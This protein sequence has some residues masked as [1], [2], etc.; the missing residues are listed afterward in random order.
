MALNRDQFLAAKDLGETVHVKELG[1]DVR[2]RSMSGADRN[3][4]LEL[5][6]EDQAN[7]DP[8][9]FGATVVAV[10]AIDDDGNRLFTLDDVPSLCQSP[11]NALDWLA[12]VGLRLSGLDSKENEERLGK[13]ETM[14]SGEPGVDSASQLAAA[15]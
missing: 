4:V 6:Q 11:A 15:P 8:A 1:G 14:A 5:I 10:C 13:S 2:L 12:V 7:K 9:K 3:V